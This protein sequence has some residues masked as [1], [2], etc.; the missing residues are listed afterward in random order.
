MEKTV[1]SR[2]EY[3]GETGEVTKQISI[4][5]KVAD[6][7][8]FFQTYVND[9]GAL[10]SL[11][12]GQMDFLVCCMTLKFVQFDTNELVINSGRRNEIAEKAGIKTA[13]IYSYMNQLKKKNILVTQGKKL[14]LNPKLFFY[15]SEI[16]RQKMLQLSINYEIC[17]DC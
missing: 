5:K 17:E 11:T 8:A 14:F 12:K 10:L 4:K 6:K 15:G 9:L 7:E 3:D 2:V 1:Y 16:E 13:S